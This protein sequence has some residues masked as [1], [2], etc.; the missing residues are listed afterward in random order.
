MFCGIEDE[1]IFP[2]LLD[3]VM[4]WGEEYMQCESGN[5]QWEQDNKAVAFLF[6]HS[7]HDGIR[8]FHDGWV[9]S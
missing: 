7:L 4:L 8:F 6:V 2:T 5:P 3:K 1:L 9:V